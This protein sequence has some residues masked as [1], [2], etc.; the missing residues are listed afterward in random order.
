MELLFPAAIGLAAGLVGGLL[1]IGGSII[2][3]P[4]LVLYLSQTGRYVGSTQHLLQAAAM[5]CNVFVAAP[6]VL[7]HKRARA[8]VGSVVLFLVPAALAG[9]LLG[10]L[11]SN[12][13]LFARHQGAYL[14]MV[15]SG[16]MVYVAGYNTWRLCTKT[17]LEHGFDQ[18]AKPAATAVAAVG[19]VMGFAA[20]LLGIGGGALC[21]P[22]QQVLLRIPLR[23]AIANSAVTILCVSPIGALFKN[24]TLSHH[25]IE[26]SESLELALLLIPTAIV[27]SYIGGRL[28]HA[29]PRRLLRVVFI[30]FMV[31]MAYLMFARAWEAR[32]APET[33]SQ[34]VS[35]ATESQA[36]PSPAPRSTV[37]SRKRLPTAHCRLRA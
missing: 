19:L 36:E 28:T 30:V 31:T 3:I 14:A 29:L 13:A 35:K 33:T 32:T 7:V 10:V 25:G 15:F 16:F 22:M 9:I 21:V 27:G 17:N 34:P 6:A 26:V 1:G 4:A 23:R 2:I 20:G 12:S 11:V 18:R 8:I 24:A 37:R 5:I